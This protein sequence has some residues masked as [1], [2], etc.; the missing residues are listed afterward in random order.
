MRTP[1]LVAVL[2]VGVVAALAAL[3]LR[4]GGAGELRLPA[5]VLVAPGVSAAELRGRPAIVHY[6]ASWCVPCRQEAPELARLDRALGD[7]AR[8]VGVDS[9]DDAGRGRA[10]ARRH[11]WSF[12]NLADPDGASGEDNGVRAL[13]TTLIVDADGRIVR[14]LFGPQTSAGLLGALR[15]LR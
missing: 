13:P 14:T 11:G 3:G 8:L 2:L 4:G 1:V 9:S 6:W 10:F 15:D 12:S 7:R 5:G